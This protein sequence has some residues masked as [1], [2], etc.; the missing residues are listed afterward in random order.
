VIGVYEKG[1]T[2][3]I[4]NVLKNLGRKRAIVVHGNDGLDEIT[5]SSDTIVSELKDGFVKTYNINARD[6]GLANI[7]MEKI[8]GGTTEENS[9]IILNILKGSKGAHR[10]IVLA[11]AAAAI[12]ASERAINLKEGMTLAAE[13]IDSGKA[14][15][16]LIGLKALTNSFS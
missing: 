5:L 2:E 10:D 16:K 13:S 15:N 11:N 12:M 1:L 4:A 8:R 14:L 9:E 3:L 7:D 6:F